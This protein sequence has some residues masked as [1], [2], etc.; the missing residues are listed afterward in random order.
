MILIRVQREKDGIKLEQLKKELPFYVV[1]YLG[2]IC[3]N[4]TNTSALSYTYK[5]IDFLE[6][7]IEYG[8][9]SATKIADVTLEEL[10][11][12][13]TEDFDAYRTYL[14]MRPNSKYHGNKFYKTKNSTATISNKL[15]ALKSL[16]KFLAKTKVRGQQNTY[17][18]HNVLLD[19]EVRLKVDEEGAASRIKINI[20][21]EEEMFDFI[22][23]VL[24]EYGTL[25]LHC[26]ALNMWGKNR[27]RDAA[28]IALLLH[29]GLRVS[30]LISIRMKDILLSECCV[31]VER[32]GSDS[33]DTKPVYFSEYAA[34]ILEDYMEI[35][36]NRYIAEDYENSPLFVTSTRG[37]YAK[38]INKNTVQ[39]MVMKYAKVYGKPYL[40][41]HDLRHS[42]ATYL[43]KETGNIRVVQDT[44]GHS[45]RCAQ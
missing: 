2:H 40:T 12:L 16:F 8:H 42:F 44:P 37:D 22:E 45:T 30:E 43:L 33:N 3:L 36:Q 14:M 21:Q 29:S 41:V 6:W 38:L 7:L 19:Y 11:D 17:L 35:R 32:K 18:S 4:M 34:E 15:S 20:L 24:H 1:K 25:N 5:I 26:V 28:I 13:Y 27:E 10:E 31:M 9:S 39:K 23:F